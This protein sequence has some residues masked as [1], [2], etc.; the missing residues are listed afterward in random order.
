LNEAYKLAVN[1]NDTI[2]AAK[3]SYYQSSLLKWSAIGMV[4]P[5]ISLKYTDQRMHEKF[6]SGS[7]AVCA[8]YG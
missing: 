2:K 8:A 1:R 3:E 5:D 4:L 7:D 6:G